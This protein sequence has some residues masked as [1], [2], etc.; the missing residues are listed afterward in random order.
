[1]KAIHF[2]RHGNEI[3]AHEVRAGTT[4]F[5]SWGRMAEVLAAANELRPGEHVKS[6]QVDERGISFRV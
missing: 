2:D 6:F 5:V 1:M 4:G 3:P